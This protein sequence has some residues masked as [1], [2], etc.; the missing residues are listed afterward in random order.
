MSTYSG[1]VGSESESDARQY[2]SGDDSEH[3]GYASKNT[4]SW[5]RAETEANATARDKKLEQL[6]RLGMAVLAGIVLLPP[7]ML[8][9][10]AL[11]LGA[12]YVLRHIMRRHGSMS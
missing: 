10:L 8:K 4:A 7:Q 3:G 5:W 1:E 9:P 11:V 6:R 2:S 12:A